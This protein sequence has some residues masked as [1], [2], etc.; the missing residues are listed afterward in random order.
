MALVFEEIVTDCPQWAKECVA[1]IATEDYGKAMVSAR[2]NFEASC[3]NK[4]SKGKVFALLIIAKV[5]LGMGELYDAKEIAEK[6]FD[7]VKGSDAKLEASVKHTLA[8]VSLKLCRFSEALEVAEEASGMFSKAGSKAGEAAVLSSIAETHLAC[9]K[10]QEAVK[11]AKQ[12]VAMFKDINEKLGEADALATTVKIHLNMKRYEEALRAAN[13]IVGIYQGGDDTARMGAS[14]LLVSDVR[15]AMGETAEAEE[16]ASKAVE[17]FEDAMDRRAQAMALRKLA[18]T[19]FANNNQTDGWTYVREARDICASI[20]NKKGEASALCQIA[21]AHVALGSFEEGGHIAEEGIKL[22]REEDYKEDLATMLWTVADGHMAE[23]MA[24]AAGPRESHLNWM[25]RKKGKE[26]LALYQH[27][28]NLAG[29]VKCLNVLSM[30]FISYGNVAEGKAKAKSAV[31]I[32]KEMEDK[33]AEGLNLLLVAQARLYDNRDE[34]LRLARLAE[35]LLKESGTP[36]EIKGA[37][38]VVEFIR[39]FE[40]TGGKKDKEAKI[41]LSDVQSEKTDITGD[42]EFGKVRKCYFHCF[43]ARLARASR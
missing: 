17:L 35:K 27:L 25:A 9:Q 7:V 31:Q 1:F 11:V 28:G 10:K 33:E 37:E 19:C 29:E 14:M 41:K 3:K 22:C 16:M 42:L 21:A 20:G 8:K 38:E 24:G 6:A 12:A 18:D 39:D 5:H 34:A 2:E 4:D 30:A 43:T 23:I 40:R 15:K 26:A 32:A 13:E 36:D